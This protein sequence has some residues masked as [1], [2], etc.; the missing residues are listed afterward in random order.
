MVKK[1][2]TK[3]ILLFVAI[4]GLAGLGFS[5]GFFFST[6]QENV[7]SD[8]DFYLALHHIFPIWVWGILIMIVSFILGLSAYF[9]PKHSINNTCNWLLCIGGFGSSFVYFLMTSASI[10]H[11]INWL[12]T[13]QFTILTI[14]CGTIGFIGGA[15]NYDRK[16]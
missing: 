5:R 6:E 12:T 16:D 13:L 10:Y 1:K 9:I 7:L 15:D 8:S 2:D 4:L 11:A 3:G 14:V